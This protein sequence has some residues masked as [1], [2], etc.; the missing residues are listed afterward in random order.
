[1]RIQIFIFLFFCALQ[2]SMG[3]VGQDTVSVYA[4]EDLYED[5]PYFWS[6]SRE[7]SIN[8]TPLASRFVPFNLGEN[9]AGTTGLVYRK[10]FSTRALKV[11]FGANLSDIVN[12]EDLFL[13]L[14]LGLEKRY[15]VSRDKKLAYSSSWELFFEGENESSSTGVMKGY[16]LEYHFSK[17]IFI[18]TQA[19]LRFGLNLDVGGP[20]IDFRLPTDLFVGVR[21]Y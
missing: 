9:I 4:E 12:E 1:M 3:Q 17:R 7:I 14:A 10:Y 8:V 20:V 2:P 15:P 13:Y 5:D 18:G 19:G 11:S 16:G 6:N 21:L